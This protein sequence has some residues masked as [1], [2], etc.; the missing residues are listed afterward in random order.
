MCVQLRLAAAAAL[1]EMLVVLEECRQA[2]R[3]SG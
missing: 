1:N 3:N 2:I